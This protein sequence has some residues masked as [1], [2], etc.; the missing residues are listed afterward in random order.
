MT[1]LFTVL[2]VGVLG[3]VVA[4]ALG[5]IGGGMADPASSLPP[6]GL[7][8]GGDLSFEDLNAVRFAPALRGYRMDQVDEVLDRFADALAQRDAEIRR[9]RGELGRADLFRLERD[10]MRLD[11]DVEG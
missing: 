3:L 2:A 8:E 1:L 11:E 4:V 5:R 10:A 7:P 6:T 9:L